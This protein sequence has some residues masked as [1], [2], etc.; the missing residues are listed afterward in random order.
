MNRA[1]FVLRIRCVVLHIDLK[2]KTTPRGTAR[3]STDE[4]L[5]PGETGPRVDPI[6]RLSSSVFIAR[7]AFDPAS[8]CYAPRV[9][10]GD[11]AAHLSV[12]GDATLVP[13]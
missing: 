5:S 8:V 12:R 9:A 1:A 7:R 3:R 6:A 4:T 2:A 13:S 10:R 11:R